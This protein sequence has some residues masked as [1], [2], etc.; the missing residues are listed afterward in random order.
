MLCLAGKGWAEPGIKQQVLSLVSDRW[1]YAQREVQDRCKDRLQ[2]YQYPHNIDFVEEL[3]KTTL[4][5]I[6]GFRLREATKME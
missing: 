4:G 3:P 2:R 5:K 6:Q 1:P